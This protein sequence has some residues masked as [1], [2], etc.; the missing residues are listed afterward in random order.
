[1]P[2]EGT[3][4]VAVKQIGTTSPMNRRER[5]AAARTATARARGHERK[6]FT[7]DEFCWAHAIS[8]AHYYV[9]KA[10]DLGPDEM[11]VLGKIIITA[12]A[13]ARWRKR[14]AAPSTRD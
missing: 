6:A 13:A 11:R 8:R 1:M 2:R 4:Y 10:H 9:L 3:D 7:I 5:R 14:T 12:E